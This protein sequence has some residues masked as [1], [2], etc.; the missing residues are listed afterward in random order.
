[1]SSDSDIIEALVRYGYLSGVSASDATKLK[2]KHPVVVEAIAKYQ[3]FCAYPLD[4]MVRQRHGRPLQAD[5]LVGPATRELF[6]MPRCEVPDFGPGSL[7]DGSLA[8][9]GSWPAPCQ[10]NGVKYHIDWRNAPQAVLSQKEKFEAD[11]VEIWRRVGVRL[12]RVATAAE[13]NIYVTFGSF[14]G[15]TI[16]LAYYNNGSCSDRCSLKMSSSYVG[17]NRGL[18]K[19]EGGHTMRMGHTRGG[20]MNAYI[21]KEEDPNGFWIPSDPSWTLIVR[22]FDG[23]P[24]PLPLPDDYVMPPAPDVPDGPPP[25]TPPTP[26][27]TPPATPRWTLRDWIKYIFEDLF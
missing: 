2:L 7:N 25:V 4:N 8:G 23:V 1:M 3:D 9:S 17:E 18:F 21:L 16:G 13:A 12:V 27:V 5:G 10:K 11:W 6:S 14:F 15:G 19:H 20:T 24:V 26:P 22:Y